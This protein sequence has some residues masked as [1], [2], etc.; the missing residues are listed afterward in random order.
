MT[1]QPHLL[2][3]SSSVTSSSSSSSSSSSGSRHP[4]RLRRLQ[5][6]QPALAGQ[7]VD[8]PQCLWNEVREACAAS[9]LTYLSVSSPP[10]TLFHRCDII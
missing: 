5:Q 4:K 8:V 6:Q 10:V 3:L 2:L 9:Q 1:R 7:L